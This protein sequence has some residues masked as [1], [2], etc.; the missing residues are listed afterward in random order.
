MNKVWLT[1]DFHEAAA[2]QLYLENTCTTFCE[3][4]AILVADTERPT[5]KL[6]GLVCTQGI[7]FYCVA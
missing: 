3:Y 5:D 2:W 1:A 6:V 7:L 4:P